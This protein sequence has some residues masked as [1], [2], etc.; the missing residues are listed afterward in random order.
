MH[1]IHISLQVE[2]HHHTEEIDVDLQLQNCTILLNTALSIA[3]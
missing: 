1:P 2:Y 3:A